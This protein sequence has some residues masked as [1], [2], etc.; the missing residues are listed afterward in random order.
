MLTQQHLKKFH[1]EYF[2]NRNNYEIKY[3]YNIRTS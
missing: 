1:I 3:T 2:E